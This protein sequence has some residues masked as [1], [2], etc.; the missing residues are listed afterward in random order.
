[1]RNFVIELSVGRREESG[2]DHCML[3]KEKRLVTHLALLLGPRHPLRYL[4]VTNY[5]L[6]YH[7]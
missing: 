7:L 5:P 4:L 3:M 1:M 6:E 2:T